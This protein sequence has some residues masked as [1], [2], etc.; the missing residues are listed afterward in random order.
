MFDSLFFMKK[1]LF[2]SLLFLIPN[3]IW[4]QSISEEEQKKFIL[5]IG[6]NDYV[7]IPKLK[8]PINDIETLAK[9]FEGFGFT[10]IKRTNL[11]SE[12]FMR[13]IQ[14]FKELLIENPNSIAIFYYAGHA[15]Q[16]D[17][18]NYLLPTDSEVTNKFDLEY[19]AIL[20]DRVLAALEEAKSGI[21]V[22]IIDAC[23]DNP[24][25]RGLQLSK[26]G[27]AE[28]ENA[29]QGTFIAYSTKP[30]GVALDQDI[31]GLSI[32]AKELAFEL[33]RAA[34][35]SI[36][37]LFKN[38]RLAVIK[39]TDGFQVPWESSS[40]T[41]NFVFNPIKKVRLPE[42]ISFSDF[43]PRLICEG[44]SGNSTKNIIFQIDTGSGFVRLNNNNKWLQWTNTL[45]A[46]TGDFWSWENNYPSENISIK[47]SFNRNDYTWVSELSEDGTK[48]QINGYCDIRTNYQILDELGD[49]SRFR[50]CN[51]DIYPDL[52]SLFKDPDI[53]ER[54]FVYLDPSNIP[55][56]KK[57]KL[58]IRILE[59]ANRDSMKNISTPGYFNSYDLYL[60]SGFLGH[61]MW[62]VYINKWGQRLLS[63]ENY[64]LNVD[65]DFGQQTCSALTDYYQYQPNIYQCSKI[66]SKSSIAKLSQSAEKKM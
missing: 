53:E 9:P 54:L 48:V 20:I 25:Q 41:G 38:T 39:R 4:A 12:N 51:Q 11:S 35:L 24:F 1:F 58:R 16:V 32:F 7:H 3:I 33:T 59:I 27:L 63:L 60:L 6:N 18:K 66:F 17:G 57:N 42:R 64:N 5:L 62:W 47:S 36:E 14:S 29:S 21:K 31:N 40:L 52:C 45:S 50:N 34:N 55:V 2:F 19:K 43:R 13:T 46:K 44:V 37:Q 49:L 26:S 56:I 15:V 10:T 30:G 22:L 23:R 65:G 61:T 28:I 8:N